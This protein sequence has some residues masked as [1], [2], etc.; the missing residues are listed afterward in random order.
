MPRSDDDIATAAGLALK[1]LLL[2]YM[3]LE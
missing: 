1:H 3:G 2:H